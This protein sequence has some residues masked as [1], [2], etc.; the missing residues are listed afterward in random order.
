MASVASSLNSSGRRPGVKFVGLTAQGRGQQR[1]SCRDDAGSVNLVLE[2]RGIPAATTAHR[3]RATFN[4]GAAAEDQ[5]R[6]FFDLSIE[7]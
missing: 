1:D 4:D 5:Y 2:N 3:G 7:E 6:R